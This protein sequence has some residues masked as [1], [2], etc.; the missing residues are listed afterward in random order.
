MIVFDDCPVEFVGIGDDEDFVVGCDLLV[1]FF[2]SGASSQ[3]QGVSVVLENKLVLPFLPSF[4]LLLFL[5]FDHKSSVCE[6]TLLSNSFCVD[7][8]DDI[9]ALETTEKPLAKRSSHE[10]ER[11][12]TTTSKIYCRDISSDVARALIKDINGCNL[13]SID[14][15]FQLCLLLWDHEWMQMKR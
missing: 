8:S 5:P 10:T 9:C 13:G 3:N 1:V 6:P 14:S 15:A 12:K 7:L 11:D 2:D 4:V